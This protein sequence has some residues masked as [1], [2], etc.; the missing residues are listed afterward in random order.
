MVEDNVYDALVANVYRAGQGEGQWA[1]VLGALV[2]HLD[3]WSAHL[4]GFEQATGTMAFSHEGGA[5]PAEAT[6][7]YIRQWHR[8]DPRNAVLFTA[9]QETWVHCHEHLSDE[10]VRTNDFYQG[11]LIPYGSRYVSG[12]HFSPS[13]ELTCVL[14]FQR[15]VRQHPFNAAERRFIERIGKHVKAA[16]L[17]QAQSRQMLRQAVAGHAILQRMRYPVLL[18]DEQRTILYENTAATDMLRAGEGLVRRGGMLALGKRE[19]NAE[20]TA[21]LNSLSTAANGSPGGPVVRPFLTMRPDDGVSVLALHVSSLLPQETM[22]A[23][24]KV[25]VFLVTVY[26]VTPH[27]QLDPFLL[28]A[29]FDLTPA[30]SRVAA[31]VA[32]GLTDEQVAERMRTAPSTVRTH[33]NN[34]YAKTGVSRRAELAMLLNASPAFWATGP[35]EQRSAR[36]N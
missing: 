35:V 33:V 29:A 32:E 36:L 25:A 9:P 14:S 12:M 11:F 22:G 1:D 27:T 16:F 10:F 21:V 7:D 31:A 28:G 23:F 4:M 20:L 18:V 15:G 30:E 8:T 24:G 13:A 3:C 2:R 17:L 6:L 26:P 34:V 19:A 5:P